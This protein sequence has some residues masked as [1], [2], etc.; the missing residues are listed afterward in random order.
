M[1][2]ADFALDWADHLILR[3][4]RNHPMHSQSQSQPQSPSPPIPSNQPPRPRAAF[5][6]RNALTFK[7]FAVLFLVLVILIP[8][9][10]IHG[11]V[12]ER[13]QRRDQAIADITASW[14]QAQDIVGPVIVIP[15]TYSIKNWEERLVDGRAVSVEVESTQTAEAFFLPADLTIEGTVVPSTRHRGIYEAVVY[16]GDFQLNGRFTPP[17]FAELDIPH[18]AIQWDNAV[19]AMA[20]S[21]LRGTSEMLQVTFAGQTLVF[22]PGSRLS[23]YHSGISVRLPDLRQLGD[24]LEFTMDL[25]LKGS[26]QIRFAPV[27]QQ[28]KVNITSPWSS[29]SF[30]GAFLP[31]S[32]TIDAD[33]F[34]AHWEASWYG[35]G[36][37][38]QSTS[39]TQPHP[40]ASAITPS[41]FGVDFIVTVDSYRLVDR[42]TK[43][44]V[45][46][47]ALIFTAFFLFEILANL[48][49]HPIQYL[50]VG[51]ALCLFYL[52]V[53]SLSEFIPF[54]TAYWIGVAASSLLI[55]LYSLKVLGSGLR[56][57]VIAAALAIVY[58]FLFVILQLQD[59]S[60]LFG[61][62]GLFV[63]L[64]LVMYATRNLDWA[65]RSTNK[66][67]ALEDRP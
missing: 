52:A 46:F 20:V 12:A 31:E 53:L 37:P 30:Q 5:L 16:D 44:A 56:T 17:D 32:Y 67:S 45:L 42:A 55:I 9:D 50:M 28:N 27:A 41:L 62:A 25:S 51:A 59:Y 21:D 13:M 40:N 10:M 65:D 54:N 33:G 64:A 29:P 18:D 58:T 34:D 57:L 63:V 19:I 49:I 48:R 11:L 22:R 2:A 38:Q 3:R 8:M 1:A 36:Y 61:T 43:Y 6:Q 60:L 39:R 4:E 47:I 24:D 26:R 35:R 7:L 23:G 66:A 15:Y 14:G